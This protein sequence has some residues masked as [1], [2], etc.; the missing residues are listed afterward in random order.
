M[1][2][3]VEQTGWLHP[4]REHCLGL[5]MAAPFVSALETNQH[6][7][8]PWASQGKHQMEMMLMLLLSPHYCCVK[9]LVRQVQ[10]INRWDM[11]FRWIAF[12]TEAAST[13]I[14]NQTP[15]LVSADYK[16]GWISRGSCAGC[17][18]P[19]LA[20]KG[21]APH[22]HDVAF[23]SFGGGKWRRTAVLS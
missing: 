2:L 18:C 6:R 3:E 16:R 4:A 9:D 17:V 15:L 14:R 20:V 23:C 13:G 21:T 22:R 10:N 5:P 11:V 12:S 19:A 8:R 7:R 1:V